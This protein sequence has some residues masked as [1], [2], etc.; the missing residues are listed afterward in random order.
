M[1]W[2]L[3]NTNITLEYSHINLKTLLEEICKNKN[4]FSHYE[5]AQWCDNLTMIFEDDEREWDDEET[6]MIGVA[7]DIEC[8]W[9]LF[10][11]NTY[12]MEELQSIDLSKV[13]L[14]QQWFIDWKKEMD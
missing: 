8:Q 10:L 9:D 12:S 1:N 7:R 13:E 3:N 5:F 11:V 6:V 14:P 2:N 4:T